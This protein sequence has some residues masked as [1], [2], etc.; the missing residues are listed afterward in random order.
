MPVYKSRAV[1]EIRRG[2]RAF[3]NLEA[4]LARGGEVPDY[5][6]LFGQAQRRIKEQNLQMERLREQLA[7]KDQ[8]LQKLRNRPAA[9]Q[10]RN[11]SNQ[12]RNG[13]ADSL[14]GEFEKRGP[15]V[16]KFTIGGKE[17]GGNFDAM[18]DTR[19]DQF[20]GAFPEPKRI[21]E[22][23]S[24]E[25][26]HTFSLASRPPVEH[27]LGVEGRQP[28]VERARFV[29]QLLKVTN[30]EFVTANLEA[31]DLASLG[32]FDVVFCSGLL[33]HLPEPWKLVEQISQVSPNLFMWTHYAAEED[34]T[35]TTNGLKGLTYKE[36][37]LADPLSGMS[38]DSFWPTLDGLQDMLR[39]HGFK[40]IDLI[41]D[42]P[43][44]PQGPAI[45]LAAIAED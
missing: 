5:E 23:G 36:L 42:V 14:R 32:E 11:N 16:T 30:A 7:R 43:S 2:L 9:N 44:H 26:G 13:E 33:Y 21:L 1:F 22:L 25:G 31:T 28:N 27:V 35:T 37:G 12:D 39:E 41:E 6:A 4:G 17:Y 8:D 38:P 45:T 34:V 20:F 40:Q 10:R 29:Q 3:L 18:R 19:I 15:W 24:L